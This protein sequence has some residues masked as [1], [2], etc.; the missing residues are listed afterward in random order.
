MQAAKLYPCRGTLPGLRGALLLYSGS[1][2]S[3]PPR[4]PAR[5]APELRAA[6]ARLAAAAADPRALEDPPLAV[7]RRRAARRRRG[8]VGRDASWA[9]ASSAAPRSRRHA[10]RHDRATASTDPFNVDAHAFTVFVPAGSRAARRRAASARAA[11][12]SAEARRSQAKLRFVP[13]RMRIGIQASIG[14]DSVVGCW[15]EGVLLDAARL[16][17]GTVLQRGDR[18]STPGR[19]SDRPASAPRLRHRMSA[20]EEHDR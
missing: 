17:R 16:G 3:T 8:A 1:T 2:R 12:R 18:T 11:R 14:F 4:R 6:A 20:G 15:P 19:A 5:C 7:P 9:A 10:A 13:P